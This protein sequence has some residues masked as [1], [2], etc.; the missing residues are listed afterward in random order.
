MKINSHIFRGYDIRGKYPEEINEETIYKIGQ[1]FADY[2]KAKQVLVAR[3]IRL[4]SERLSNFLIKGI[5]S[6]GVRVLDI[7]LS[8][9]PCFYFAV[10]TSKVDAGLMI[11]ASH[12]GKE[13]N[14]LKLVLGKNLPLT[15]DEIRELKKATIN[16]E[17][18]ILSSEIMV[19]KKDF[20]QIYI[21][22]IRSFIKNEFKPLKI[23]IDAGNGMAGLYLEKIFAETGLKLIFIFTELDGS[24]PNRDPNPKISTNRQKIVEKILAEKADLGVMFDSDADRAYF[25]DR[26]GEVIDPNLVSALIAEYLIKQ[27]GKNK[28]LVEVRT[29]RAVEDYVKKLGGEVETSVCWTIPMKLK[30][31]ENPEI[32]FGS[33][34]SGHYIFANFYKIDDAILAAINFLQIISLKKQLIDEIIDE[35]KK[36][37]FIIEETNFRIKDSQQTEEILKILEEKYKKQGGKIIKIDGLTVKFNNWWYNLRPSETEPV[38]RLNLEADNKKLMEEKKREISLLIESLIQLS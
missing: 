35:F 2:I 34:T 21:D 32:I 13:F 30:M 22:T 9:T 10:A 11:T 26:D 8:S 36:K 3:D 31:I 15:R 25:L 37:Y 20:S 7:G 17:Y 16:K 18:N 23:V 6:Q 24:F 33:E 38:I 12:L 29:S 27:T 5:N 4:S 14:G 19:E 28:V 1:A